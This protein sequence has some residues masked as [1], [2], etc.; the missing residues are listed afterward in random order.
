MA[1]VA[2][3][4]QLSR[5]DLLKAAGWGAGCAAML[6]GCS[7]GQS[8]ETQTFVL[9]HPAWHGAWFWKKVVPL[10][11]QKGHRVSTPTLTGLGERSHLARPGVGLDMHVTDVVHVLKYEELRDVVLVGHSS[12]GAVI[13][14]VADR[15]PTH[16]AH[17]I[18]LDA[19]V[20][21]DGQAVLDLITPERRQTM[22]ALVKAEGNGWLLPRF[23]PP[24]WETIVRDMW[25]VINEDDVRWMLDRLDP[26]P[27]GH[28]K[29]PV[30][31]TNPA[32]EKLPRT[33]VRFLQFPNPR[34]DQHAEMAKRTELWRYRELAAPHH[35]P[36][37]MPDKVADLLV[38]LPT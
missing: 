33:Y 3:R 14:G 2:S 24:P 8:M 32:A 37:T 27:F 5:R 34:F 23:A 25:G 4:G 21:D 30:Q 31:R 16:I 36:V 10:L 29:D 19:F 1:T 22:E 26:T 17:V 7:A 6:S 12:S 15:A 38:E 20:P 13:T 28:L 18:Y 35:A 9:V 11:Q